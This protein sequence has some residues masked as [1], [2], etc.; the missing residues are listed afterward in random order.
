M[1]APLDPLVSTTIAYY[2]RD[3]FDGI[4]ENTAFWP[5][6]KQQGTIT[7]DHGGDPI[8]GVINAGR[9][10]PVTSAPGMDLSAL[11]TT[12][13]RHVRYNIPFGEITVPGR[14]DRGLLRRNSSNEAL[15]DLSK[16][17][18]PQMITDLI[19]GPQVLTAA[20]VATGE[21]SLSWN[22]LNQNY[23]TYT[24]GGLPFYGFPSFLLQPAATGLNGFNPDTK[25]VSG[26][27]PAAADR[28][29]IPTATSQ[30]YGGLTMAY[31]GLNTAVNR[32][33]PDAWTPTLVNLGSSVWT[34][35]QQQYAL[36]FPSALNWAVQRMCRF[37]STQTTY[38]GDFGLM[39]TTY[40]RYLGEFLATK[41]T[42]YMQP[43]Q[44][45][46]IDSPN[47]GY[48]PRNRFRH[49]DLWH[50]IDYNMPAN[51]W[52]GINAEQM[53]VLFQKLFKDGWYPNPLD[54]VTGEDAGIIEPIAMLDP[55]TRSYV[56]SMTT[57]GQMKANV[58]YF[59]RVGNYF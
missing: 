14:L 18:V 29:V 26:G 31:N 19:T 24:G 16:T 40:G 48:A 38:R 30:T 56:L 20:G 43:M 21:G 35:T 25:V 45:S 2:A 32:A 11:T 57:A 58:R 50:Y 47:L 53:E 52:Y 10:S 33:E 7:Y 15:V 49:A 17:E 23:A 55:M 51:S 54:G 37:D 27:A 4:K 13:V 42:I 39:D 28:E 1:A 22:L 6:F 12:Q 9:Y 46:A 36:A 59:A 44:D 3:I 8:I 5:I 41:Q 34:G